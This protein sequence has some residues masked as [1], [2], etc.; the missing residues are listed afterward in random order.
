MLKQDL[1]GTYLSK[2]IRNEKY[3]RQN[4]SELLEYTPAHTTVQSILMYYSSSAVDQ[5]AAQ[6]IQL[7]KSRYFH[8][9]PNKSYW[10]VAALMFGLRHQCQRHACTILILPSVEPYGECRKMSTKYCEHLLIIQYTKRS[11]VKYLV[12]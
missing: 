10:I 5:I 8:R 4:T 3:H 6:Q 2:H 12:L 7:I 1:K 11:S 9:P